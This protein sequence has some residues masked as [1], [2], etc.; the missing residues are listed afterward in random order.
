MRTLQVTDAKDLFDLTERF[1]AIGTKDY[2]YRCHYDLIRENMKEGYVHKELGTFYGWSAAYAALHG[3]R[4]LHLVDIDFKPFN[5]HK[6]YFDEYLKEHN[7]KLRLYNCSSHDTQCVG[8]CDT[9]LIDS[10]HTWPWVEKEL[11]LHA[12]SVRDWIVFHDTQMIHGKPSPIGPGV[13]QWL[14]SNIVGSQFEMAEELTV[15]V[16]AML[17]KRK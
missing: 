11:E 1:K 17:I 9:M 7:G 8:P 10:V 14:K 4:E 3:A 12:S 5:T 13:K 6:K 15:G 2:K 16:G